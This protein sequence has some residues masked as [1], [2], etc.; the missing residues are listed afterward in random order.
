MSMSF[1]EI[2][3]YSFVIGIIFYAISTIAGFYSVSSDSYL[4]YLIFYVFIMLSI[5]IVKKD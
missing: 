3:T 4:P 5:S 1:S 2:L